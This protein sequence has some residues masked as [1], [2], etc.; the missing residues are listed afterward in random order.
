MLNTVLPILM[1]TVFPQLPT[2]NIVSEI[3]VLLIMKS[4]PQNYH[5]LFLSFMCL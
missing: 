3:N 4:Q 5:E 1:F 2:K